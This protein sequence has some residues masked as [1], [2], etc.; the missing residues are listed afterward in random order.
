MLHFVFD[1][2]MVKT[3]RVIFRVANLYIDLDQLIFILLSRSTYH[4]HSVYEVAPHNGDVHPHCDW[5]K[6]ICHQQLLVRR[7]AEFIFMPYF[8]PYL[9][10]TGG[11]F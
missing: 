7:V 6:H 4:L 8:M 11:R 5:P 1:L 10:Q 2:V 3:G 9:T